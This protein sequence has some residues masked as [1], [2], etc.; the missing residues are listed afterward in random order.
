MLSLDDREKHIRFQSCLILGHSI[1]VPV[2]T[3]QSTC[4]F[5]IL[6]IFLKTC[7]FLRKFTSIAC[8]ENRK[9]YSGIFH[10][11][12]VDTA[13][14]NAHINALHKILIFF[15]NAEISVKIACN[16]AV[17][18]SFISVPLRACPHIHM[19]VLVVSRNICNAAKSNILSRAADYFAA[20]RLSVL[21]VAADIRSI[22]LGMLTTAIAT[23]VLIMSST[24]VTRGHNNFRA[25]QGRIELFQ[26]VHEF[27]CNHNIVGLSA[28]TTKFLHIE[29]R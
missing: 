5:G 14:V 15:L 17:P 26:L 21:T 22:A 8:T 2:S 1:G 3:Y 11:L 24:S 7:V 18:L 6:V 19:G 28:F 9:L 25:V 10:F 29:M 27:L 13:V 23:H 12:P 20:D 4:R 16:C